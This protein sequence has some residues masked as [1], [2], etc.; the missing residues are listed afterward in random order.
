MTST[1]SRAT[2]LALRDIRRAVLSCI[3]RLNKRLFVG[4]KI[5]PVEGNP[6]IKT[7]ID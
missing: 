1:F 4:L 7:A 3:N 5:Y 6:L 2:N